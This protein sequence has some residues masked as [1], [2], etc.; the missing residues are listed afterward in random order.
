M[1]VSMVESGGVFTGVPV[2]EDLI[3]KNVAQLEMEGREVLL[4]MEPETPRVSSDQAVLSKESRENQ[5]GT[6]NVSARS[7][8]WNIEMDPLWALLITWY[9][10]AGQ[11]TEEMILQLMDIYRVLF[12]NLMENTTGQNQQIQ[13]MRLEQMLSEVLNRIWDQQLGDMSLLFHNYGTKDQISQLKSE[14]YRLITGQRLGKQDVE[15]FWELSKGG[16]STLPRNTTLLQEGVLTNREMRTYHS[17]ERQ[18]VIYQPAKGSGEKGKEVVLKSFAKETVPLGNVR[19]VRMQIMGK[20]SDGISGVDLRLANKLAAY[21]TSPDN[22]LQLGGAEERSEELHGF[23]ASVL[24][25]QSREFVRSSGM[26]STMSNFI[27]DVVDRMIDRHFRQQAYAV[28]QR[29]L[30]QP[31]EK[32]MNEFSYKDAYGVHSHITN[33][34]QKHWRPDRAIGEGIRYAIEVFSKKREDE[35]LKKVTRYGKDAGFFQKLEGVDISSSLW[36]D[37]RFGKMIIEKNWGM[38]L[39][40]TGMLGKRGISLIPLDQS[41]WGCLVKTQ[42]METSLSFRNYIVVFS[43]ILGFGLLLLLCLRFF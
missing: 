20:A 36:M 10:D 3:Q 17:V 37:I 21:L 40:Y 2:S 4:E 7:G 19:D 24:Q 39:A 30:N 25:I 11:S 35:T 38:F 41:F 14:I 34:Y 43:G 33:A 8:D 18:G 1:P 31:R 22:V 9:P 32:Q 15:N 13:L 26:G 29:A 42:D 12:T 16:R 27:Y 28:E 23:L 6:E 5:R